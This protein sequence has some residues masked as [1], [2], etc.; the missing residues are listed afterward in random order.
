MGLKTQPAYIAQTGYLHPAEL[1]RNLIEGLFGRTGS[2]RYGDFAVTPTATSGQVS[3]APGRA[4]LVGTENA[5]QGAYF[6]W[7]DAADTMIF[8]A[9][10]GNP[11]IDTLLMRVSDDQYGTIS[12]SPTAYFD[13]VQGVA[14]GSPV[15]RV[16]ADFNSGGSFY[17]P[18]A[19]WRVADIRRNLGDTTIPGG[20][21]TSNLRYVRNTSSL[22][23]AANSTA[24]TA[25]T[26]VV[27]GD[28]VYQIDTKRTYVWD[29]TWAIQAKQWD[30][31]VLYRTANQSITSAVDTLLTWEG[32]VNPTPSGYWT[33]GNPSRMVLPNTGTWELMLKGFGDVGNVGFM[34]WFTK[35]GVTGTRISESAMAYASWGSNFVM[36]FIGDFSAGDY[37]EARAF[38]NS[39]GAVNFRNAQF[40]AKQIA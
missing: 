6:T 38:Q 28:R 20:Q 40:V 2:L 18:G 24:R 25:I 7:S 11:R 27:L 19:W 26:D 37:M 30:T 31:A 13:I 5:Q 34:S 33:A 29:G 36:Y 14:A 23:L 16:D 9:A 12:G 15:A 21:I 22:L 35:N 4:C 39:G 32:V 10:S 1:D 3:I 17:V 8:A